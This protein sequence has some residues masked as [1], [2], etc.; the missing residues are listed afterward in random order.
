MQTNTKNYQC[1]SCTAPLRFDAQSTM[2][3]CDHCTSSFTVAEIDPK[4]A[5]QRQAP[6]DWRQSTLSAD[7]GEDA[8]QMRSYSCTSCG[9]ELICDATTAATS[10]HYCGN[11]TVVPAQFEGSLRPDYIIPFRLT[12]ED[13]KNKL[14]EHCKG[15]FLLPN[16]FTNE[17][18]IE[19]LK[20]VYVPFWLFDGNVNADVTYKASN[21]STVTSGNYKVTTTEH[22]DV[23]R[24]G[25]IAFADVPVDSSSKMP[26][27]YM[28]SIEPFDYSEMV[29]FSTAYM[30]GYLAD[31]YDV[32]VSKC[33][34]RADERSVQSA[35][36]LIRN[37]VK[38]TT[39]KETSNNITLQRGDVRYAMA[40]VWMLT[41]KFRGK[42]FLFAMNA[43]TG[44]MAG[45]LPC[46][47]LKY[48]G[49]VAAFTPIFGSI[50]A[51]IT[52][53]IVNL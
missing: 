16:V 22:Y 10:C 3:Q 51:L 1:P 13:A 5:Q 4:N 23:R 24:A 47:R 31:K 50:A 43:Q 15:K 35:M 30:P 28:E 11:N 49:L 40:P 48:W 37:S 14:K 45:D 12:K 2:L 19:E 21:S 20:G 53:L 42:V 36:S 39:V 32:S 38:Y 34:P 25:T 6:N 17:L 27:E 8:P 44:K 26:D 46:S 18:H 52:Y 29:P 7:W 41:T 9:A 33:T